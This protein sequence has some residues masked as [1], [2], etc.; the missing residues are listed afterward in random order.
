MQALTP[1]VFP[2]YAAA[3]REVAA[4]VAAFLERGAD[5]RLFLD[6]GE[7]RPGEDLAGK[8]REARMADVVLV[9]FSR[10]SMPS[11]WPRSEWE[12]ALCTEPAAELTRIGR[13]S[14]RERVLTD[15]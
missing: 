10:N 5:V 14:C 1:S 15:V 8:A 4:G 9:L 3:D 13:A 6:E 12:D 2:C 7:M 11:R